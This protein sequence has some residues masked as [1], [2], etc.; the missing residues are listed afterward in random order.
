MTY[1]D[2]H[3]VAWLYQ[4]DVKRL[5]PK[6][7]EQIEA[8]SDLRISP[9]VRLELQYM[10]ELKRLAAPASN[11]IDALNAA[12]GLTICQAPFSAVAREADLHGW[13]RDPFDRLIVAQA[14]MH[15]AALLTKDQVIHK[16]YERAVW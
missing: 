8:D 14:A 7:A 6:A 15:E 9:I 2:T 12:I 11:A 1:L 4:H 13:T 16:H 5:S 10:Y 3:V